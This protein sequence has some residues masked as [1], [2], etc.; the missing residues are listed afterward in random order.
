MRRRSLPAAA[1]VPVRDQLG[2]VQ[3]RHAAQRAA[4]EEE[5]PRLR[6]HPHLAAVLVG[7]LRCRLLEGCGLRLVDRAPS[8]LDGKRREAQIVPERRL[9]VVGTTDRVDRAVATG[10]R[11]ELR[12]ALAE[13]ELVT[14]VDA[15]AVLP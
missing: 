6:E 4:G 9:E 14:P 12:L 5:G 13:P 7:A 11:A 3:R 10:D 1:K 8:L 15:L 2:R